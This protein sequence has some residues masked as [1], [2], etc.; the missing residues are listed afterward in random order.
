MTIGNETYESVK[1]IPIQKGLELFLN[2]TNI[3][4]TLFN[5]KGSDNED[6][7]NHESIDKD[8]AKFLKIHEEAKV[9]TKK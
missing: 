7:I 4:S 6:I 8:F 5:F 9:N 2:F 1:N 3:V